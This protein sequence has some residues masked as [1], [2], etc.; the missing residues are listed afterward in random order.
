MS[1]NW[2][3][4]YLNYSD[5]TNGAGAAATSG[6]NIPAP[7][8]DLT[9]Y[10]EGPNQTL[11]V[12][13]SD[14]SNQFFDAGSDGDVT[15]LGTA[16]INTGSGTETA[17]IGMESFG[18]GDS[19]QTVIAVF[20]PAGSVSGGESGFV[21]NNP[22]FT[23]SSVTADNYVMPAPCFLGGTMIRT[24]EGERAVEDLHTGDLV[25]TADGSQKPLR[26]V[27]RSTVH[28]RFADPVRVLP[29]RIKAGALGENLPARDLLV[30][31]SHAM[32]LDG[33]LVQASA[34]VNG[35]SIVHESRVPR[36]FIYYHLETD[37]HDLLLAEG[38]PTESF[39][40]AAEDMRFDNWAERPSPA[41][42]GVELDYPRV[43]SARQVP[44]ALR[45]M[46]A[47]RAVAIG[48]DVDAA[49]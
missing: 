43:K 15:Y 8:T 12:N 22:G 24:P 21:T 27:G 19:A 28:T 34:L 40:I 46:L 16:T 26:W 29:I 39:L 20:V 44:A 37:S 35:T 9:I 14:S 11:V 17:V 7:S 49:A 1:D 41:A 13:G 38:A 25:L 48:A 30:S 2:D 36:T 5:Y 3:V 18:S 33:V 47:A 4:Y 45:E 42:E 32:L 31:P 6:G 23:D 10:V